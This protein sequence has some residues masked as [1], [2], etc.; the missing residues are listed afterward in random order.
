MLSPGAPA[1]VKRRRT[2]VIFDDE[3]TDVAVEQTYGI[4]YGDAILIPA[5]ALSEAKIG[6]RTKAEA[7]VQIGEINLLDWEESDIQ[8]LRLAF[9]ASTRTPAVEVALEAI[10]FMRRERQRLLGA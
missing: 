7:L 4:P 10:D 9:Q 1:E 3:Q 2:I 6:I 5:A 8:R